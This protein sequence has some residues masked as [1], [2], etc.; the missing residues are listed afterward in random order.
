M[1]SLLIM[2][3]C[4]T[5]VAAAPAAPVWSVS[6]GVDGLNNN[7]FANDFY[8]SSRLNQGNEAKYLTA[9]ATWSNGTR[10][11]VGYAL[12]RNEAPG[13]E[14]R[15]IMA[16]VDK[17][18]TENWWVTVGYE[19]SFSSFG[20]INIGAIYNISPNAAVSFV[21]SFNNSDYELKNAILKTQLY[22]RF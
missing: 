4:L 21:S 22:I 3:V 12:G 1:M 10:F 13:Y 5:P 20:G 18:I 7:Y 6:F 9:S 19:G 17:K 8:T 2:L 14:N 15:I 16:G 11:N